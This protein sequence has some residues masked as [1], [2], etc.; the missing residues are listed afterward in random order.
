[1]DAG[2]DEKVARSIG[3]IGLAGDVTSEADIETPA[4][5]KRIVA[6]DARK[7][8]KVWVLDSRGASA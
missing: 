7:N 5:G 3:G 2:K 4:D 6:G 8:I 1:M